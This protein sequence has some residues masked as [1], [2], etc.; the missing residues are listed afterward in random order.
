[1]IGRF[2]FTLYKDWRISCHSNPLNKCPDLEFCSHY[3]TCYDLFIPDKN[4][5]Q[6]ERGRGVFVLLPEML[7]SLPGYQAEGLV[8]ISLT[9]TGDWDQ[10]PRVSNLLHKILSGCSKHFKQ[11][12]KK[13]YQKRFLKKRSELVYCSCLLTPPS[14]EA[15]SGVFFQ[16]CEIINNAGDV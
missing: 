13:K 15:N 11:F 5:F 12:L 2:V 3:F 6:W 16:T 7:L 1:M 10:S 4:V 8:A 9:Q 14:E